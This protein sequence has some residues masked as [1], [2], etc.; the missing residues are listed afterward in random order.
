M[1]S[2]SKAK[3]LGGVGSGLVFLGMIGIIPITGQLVAV[4]GYILILIAVKYISDA[5]GDASIFKNMLIALVT[6]S[7]GMVAGTLY[8]YESVFRLA[9]LVGL[10]VDFLSLGLVTPSEVQ[11]ADF[12]GL[13]ASVIIGVLV[14]WILIMASAVY[15]R[16]SYNSISTKLNVGMFGTVATLY[17]LGAVLSIIG[18]GFIFI[19]VV[20]VLQIV[21]FFRIPYQV[22]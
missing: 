18:V 7:L 10:S 14:L 5:I 4:I 22:P 13:I 16:K 19:V 15:M 6:A 12:I 3:T 1:T 11:Q 2:L 21:A 17:L 8:V 9:G 20:Q